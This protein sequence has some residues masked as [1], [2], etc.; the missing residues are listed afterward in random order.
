MGG[1]GSLVPRK[2]T[3]VLSLTATLAP[4]AK[5]FPPRPKATI[6]S[7]HTL[8]Y[9]F[10]PKRRPSY[11]SLS[12]YTRHRDIVTRCGRIARSILS[13]RGSV[14]SILLGHLIYLQY[15]EFFSTNRQNLAT[16]TQYSQIK[17]R[18]WPKLEKFKIFQM[19]KFI[20]TV[21][22]STNSFT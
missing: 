17:S 8:D 10:M 13:E 12:P 18:N 16:H 11:D 9:Y 14:F 7:I 20:C 21:M 4:D 1:R 22:F 2:L 19:W 3:S 15:F 5:K 6:G